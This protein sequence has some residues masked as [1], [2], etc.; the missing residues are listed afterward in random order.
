MFSKI[1][2]KFTKED[3]LSMRDF[4][5]MQY[6]KSARYE[7]NILRIITGTEVF[8]LIF[9]YFNFNHKNPISIVYMSLY[10]ILA[11]VS[12]ITDIILSRAQKKKAFKKNKKLSMVAYFYFVFIVVW[13]LTVTTLDLSRGGSFWVAATVM[14]AIS[15]YLNLNPFYTC[16]VI[17]CGGIYLSW[18][19][20]Y[21]KGGFSG[22]VINIVVFCFVD[23]TII[24]KN[25]FTMYDNA[26]MEYKLEKLSYRD[27]L[28]G[29]NNRR[30]LD[31][32]SVGDISKVK[33][34]G[35]VDID[36]FKKINDEHGHAAGDEAL[37]RVT[38]LFRECFKDKE[39]YRYGGDEFVFLSGKSAK[40]T[41]DILESIN[42]R[43]FDPEAEVPIHLSGGI[44]NL[45]P[46]E[47]I[48]AKVTAADALLYEAKKEGK[49]KIIKG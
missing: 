12:L 29:I 38:A 20:I 34:V 43:L 46:G 24:L 6:E 35:I 45:A 2:S 7:H 9:G 22:N 5:R 1:A 28:T 39:I 30:A 27:A 44:L 13:A 10:A 15:V 23:C 3:F 8:M 19:S 14:M 21:L 48:P 42:K 11:V 4:V 18:L 33:S 16:A 25:Y 40:E 41:G 47:S 26:Y 31:K 32:N 37:L 49:A 17:T 36:N